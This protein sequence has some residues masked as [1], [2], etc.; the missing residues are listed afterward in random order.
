[1]IKDDAKPD[2]VR[3]ILGWKVYVYDRTAGEDLDAYERAAK[4]FSSIGAKF[5]AFL[6]SLEDVSP[7]Q[8]F[9]YVIGEVERQEHMAWAAAKRSKVPVSELGNDTGKMQEAGSKLITRIKDVVLTKLLKLNFKEQLAVNPDKLRN[10]GYSFRPSDTLMDNIVEYA[11]SLTASLRQ[12]TTDLFSDLE[13]MVSSPPGS[14][15]G[16]EAIEDAFKVCNAVLARVQG[17]GV[18]KSAAVP[19]RYFIVDKHP[20]SGHGT[21]QKAG[22]HNDGMRVNKDGKSRST[23]SQ[24]THRVS[25]YVKQDDQPRIVARN[26]AHE[27]GHVL[28]AINPDVQKAV[29]AI[30]HGGPAPSAYGSTDY[31]YDGLDAPIVHHTSG[32]EWMAEAFASIVMGEDIS[33]IGTGRIRAFKAAVATINGHPHAGISYRAG[34]DMNARDAMAASVAGRPP[35]PSA[36]QKSKRRKSERLTRK[37]P[38]SP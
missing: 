19:I 11:R 15:A 10:P 21:G 13:E 8:L 38:E 23:N 32:N 37:Q 18:R 16:P 31:V 24:D 7:T 3:D 9:A 36:A 25:V 28:F 14:G 22:D 20:R 5:K 29:A 34:Q 17:I 1:M 12:S 30:A 2:A 6:E 26:L 33:H 35:V 27:I 4:S